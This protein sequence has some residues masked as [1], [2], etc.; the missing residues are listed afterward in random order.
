MISESKSCRCGAVSI[1]LCCWCC[2]STLFCSLAHLIWTHH[3]LCCVCAVL[4][5]EHH[6]PFSQWPVSLSCHLVS[7]F[8]FFFSSSFLHLHHQQLLLS[9]NHLLIETICECECKFMCECVF[10]CVYASHGRTTVQQSDTHTHRLLPLKTW[11]LCFLPFVLTNWLWFPPSSSSVFPSSSPFECAW[12]KW[13]ISVSKR[14]EC[15]LAYVWVWVQVQLIRSCARQRNKA[16]E[17]KGE[18]CWERDREWECE[19]ISS[20]AFWTRVWA[21]TLLSAISIL[22]H[23]ACRQLFSV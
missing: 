4:L 13:I 1:K 15:L 12:N 22:N 23:Q 16:S 11:A 20:A 6:Q 5:S 10:E 2:S 9:Y 3:H 17:K 21:A 19:W 18:E 8:F 14:C 7:V